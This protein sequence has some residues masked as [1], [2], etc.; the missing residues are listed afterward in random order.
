MKQKTLRTLHSEGSRRLKA[1]GIPE[2]DLDAWL[3]LEYVTGISRAQALA[4]PEQ[5]LSPGSEA[6]YQ[7]C[8]E[9]RAQRIPLQ[10]ITGEQEFFGLSFLVNEAVLIPR[11]D[12]EILVEEAL[13]YLRPGMRILD[14]GT[15]SGCILLSLLAEADSRFSEVSSA[16]DG[17]REGGSRED[18]PESVSGTGTD[19]S[20]E[21]LAVARENAR[22]LHLKADFRQSD[23]FEN[24]DGT[25]DLIVSN[26]PYI[27]T[28]D[29]DG[30]QEEVRHDPRIALDGG[31]DGLT[32]IRQIIR[33]SPAH[34]RSGG[35]LLLEIGSDEGERT[36]LL[37]ADAGFTDIMVKK[38]LA[39]LD[40]VVSGRYNI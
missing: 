4:D 14:I 19:I 34:L 13:K 15:G 9:K 18:G 12:T 33:E 8:I 36:G 21:A 39:D 29:L 32:L 5:A 22:R 23:L 11:Q 7:N 31:Q 26:P 25:F 24:V 20:S 10:Q 2:A 35:R 40:R 17:S 3:L 1:A 16:K 27:P 30:L 37:F 6:A 28:E 38:D